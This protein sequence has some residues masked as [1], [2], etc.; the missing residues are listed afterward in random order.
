MVL[1]RKKKKWNTW[2]FSR[3][4]IVPV[5]EKKLFCLWKKL[6][7][8]HRKGISAFSASVI[9]SGGLDLQSEA[10]EDGLR[11]KSA[12]PEHNKAEKIKAREIWLIYCNVL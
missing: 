5:E 8:N 6:L 3:E 9:T 4:G 11:Y 1:R 2:V 7:S 12:S 10:G